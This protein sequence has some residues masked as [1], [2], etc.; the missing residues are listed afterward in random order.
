MANAMCHCHC[1]KS[2]QSCPTL[3]DPMD[4][5]TSGSSV[6]GILQARVVEWVAIPSSRGSSWPSDQTRISYVSCIYRQVLYHECHLGSPS[7]CYTKYYILYDFWGSLLP[8]KSIWIEDLRYTKAKKW[9]DNCQQKGRLLLTVPKRKGHARPHGAA[10]GPI[11]KQREG[12]FV[13]KCLYCGFYGREW[14][15]QA[16][17]Y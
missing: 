12:E 13:G 14:A 2:L 3:C 7:I 11:K 5:N 9:E 4:C 16:E 15:R 8:K 17:Q 6:L 1:A 10:P